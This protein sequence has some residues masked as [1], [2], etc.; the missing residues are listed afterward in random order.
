VGPH[1]HLEGHG[2]NFVRAAAKA[3]A[4]TEASLQANADLADAEY[5]MFK[6]TE[7]IVRA[8]YEERPF[9]PQ[10]QEWKE[11]HDE[12]RKQMPKE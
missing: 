8:A 3:E 12:W 7:P 2:E 9:D 11:F 10:V 5:K 6:A 1:F 4:A